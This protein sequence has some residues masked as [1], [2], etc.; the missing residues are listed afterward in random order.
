MPEPSAPRITPTHALGIYAEP[1]ATGRRVVVVGDATDGLGARL[2]ELG[3]RVVHVYDPDAARAATAAASPGRGVSVRALPPGDFDVRDGAFDV[4]IVPDLATVVDPAALVARLRRLVGVEGVALVAARNPAVLEGSA[5]TTADARTLDYYEL[6]D[7]V[8]LQFASVRM[9][10]QVPF[11]GVAIAE[12]GEADGAPQVSVDTQLVP[13][14]DPPELFIALASQRDVRLD[15]YAIV[16]LPRPSIRAETRSSSA[17]SDAMAAALAEAQLR[18]EVLQ[19]QIEEQRLHLTKLSATEARSE[20][21]GARVEELETALHSTTAKLREVEARAGDTHVRAERIGH[22]L[23]ALE[24]ELQRQR[25]RA[26]R[27]TRELEDEKKARTKAELELTMVRKSPELAATRGRVSDLE[28]AL[29]AAEV[30]VSALQSRVDEL[31]AIAGASTAVVERFPALLAELEATRAVALAGDDATRRLGEIAQRA[32]L[33]E[34]RALAFE[35]EIAR[36]GDANGEEIVGLEAALR[37]RAQVVQALERELHR[38]ERIVQDLV[39]AL[40]EAHVSS[41]APAAFHAPAQV[42]AAQISEV[43]EEDLRRKLDALATELA[44]REGDAQAS[45]WRIGE[46]EQ[47]L[48]AARSVAPPA[49]VPATVPPP[50]GGLAAGDLERQL[51]TAR[52][53]VDVLKQALAQEHEARKKV[54]AGDEL[55]RARAELQRQATLI[56]Q[57][58]GELDARDARDVSRAP[59]TLGPA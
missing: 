22:D 53:E 52:D 55:V 4:A 5:R 50:P 32:E 45:A 42:P 58:S 59:G 54:E 3:A 19:A 46:L 49:M 35:A 37:E 17:A 2:A 36:H 57:L 47:E 20:S 38:R 29:R 40:E 31:E 48:A 44:R 18:A 12:L 23:R 39:H 33:L 30:V 6:Y 21:R 14:A 8:S 7:L 56:E 41:D 13:E 11:H 15:P 25:D 28:E 51:A 9:I 26:T 10:G 24:E 27:L 43:A 1:L 16:Q 34:M